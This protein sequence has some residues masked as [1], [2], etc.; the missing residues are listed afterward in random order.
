MC[1]SILESASQVSNA[2]EFNVSMA[3]DLRRKNSVRPIYPLKFHTSWIDFVWQKSD[4]PKIVH[5]K[6]RDSFRNKRHVKNLMNLNEVVNRRKND[7]DFAK[8]FI[9]SSSSISISYNS[10]IDNSDSEN[11]VLKL[12]ALHS[13]VNCQAYLGAPHSFAIQMCQLSNQGLFVNINYPDALVDEKEI[14]LFIS[15]LQKKLNY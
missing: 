14:N 4:T 7:V 10:K 15:F 5:S 6:I 11:C 8:S 12:I 1:A 13:S 9:A 3:V 2:D